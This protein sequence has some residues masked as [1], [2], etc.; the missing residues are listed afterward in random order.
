MIR[1]QIEEVAASIITR[2]HERYDIVKMDDVEYI[3]MIKYV[4]QG[5]LDTAEENELTKADREK[6]EQDLYRYAKGLYIQGCML[7]YCKQECVDD[8]Y[9]E[10]NE[11]F[12]YIYSNEC[13]PR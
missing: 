7:N 13:Y 10:S 8:A 6:L 4:I 11:W 9:Q 3:P 12:D 1:S 5:V 2:L